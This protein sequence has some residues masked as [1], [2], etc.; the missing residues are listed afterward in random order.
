MTWYGRFIYNYMLNLDTTILKVDAT[1]GET[2]NFTE[3][4][5]EK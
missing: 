1:S 5:L 3:N 4:K 2:G